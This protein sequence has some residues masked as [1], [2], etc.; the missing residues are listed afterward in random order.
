MR[1]SWPSGRGSARKASELIREKFAV[2]P[3]ALI[4]SDVDGTLL[5]ADELVTART[6]AAV[7]AAIAGGATFV[8]ATGRPPRWIGMVVDALGFA[9]M[10]VCANGAVLYDPGRGPD[11]LGADVCP[12]TMLA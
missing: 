11:H 12:P 8:L 2:N 6:R 3:P 4:A 7:R 1:R 5:D 10:A 9:P